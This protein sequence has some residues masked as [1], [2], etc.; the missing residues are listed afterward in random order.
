MPF[1][2]KIIDKAKHPNTSSGSHSTS[3]TLTQPP[4]ARTTPSKNTNMDFLPSTA[5]PPA[6]PP[7]SNS[8]SFDRTSKDAM[9]VD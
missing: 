3:D 1:F 8:A 2:G 6:S 5:V 4:P 9:Q 7:H